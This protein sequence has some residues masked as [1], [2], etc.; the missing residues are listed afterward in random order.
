MKRT[1]LRFSILV[2]SLF[3]TGFAASIPV[4]TVNAV[5]KESTLTVSM[6][7]N[8]L[9]LTVMPSFGGTFA[10][11]S[12]AQISV[13]TDNFTGYT[14]SIATTDSTSLVNG[15]DDEIESIS[16]NISEATFSAS[17]TYNNKWGYKPSQYVTISNNV[18]TVVQNS[19]YLPAPSTAGD[20]LAI[21]HAAN[22]TG[23]SNNYTLS[24]GVRVDMNLPADTYDTTYVLKVVAN[25]IVYN[26]TYD[27][28]AR[29]GETISGMP[30]P[31]PQVLEIDGGTPVADSYGTLSN[32]VPTMSASTIRTFGGW[33]TTT[34]TYNSNTGNDEC[35]GTIYQPGDDYPIDQTADGSNIT[36]YAI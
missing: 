17:S 14:A 30:S 5:A 33:C 19:D 8:V 32:A 22:A 15:N 35:A 12:N 6:P 24:F 36:L 26:I 28:N 25:S 18:E 23:T 2:L 16:S 13:S 10:K 29:Q 4:D 11:S 3:L 21:T 27:D 31:N 34:T 7:T 1:L 20:L 9:Q